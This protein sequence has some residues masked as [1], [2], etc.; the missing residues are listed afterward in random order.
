MWGQSGEVG[1]PDLVDRQKTRA[2]PHPQQ[3][4]QKKGTSYSDTVMNACFLVARI[5]D[6]SPR[7]R[8]EGKG[9]AI[10]AGRPGRI[11]RLRGVLRERSAHMD[12]GVDTVKEDQKTPVFDS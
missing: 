12:A 3:A 8:P 1:L 7:C 10:Q 2:C 9:V 11:S 4:L 6:L 5:A